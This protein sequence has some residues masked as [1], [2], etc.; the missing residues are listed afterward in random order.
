MK[1]FALSSHR[2]VVQPC[3]V[4]RMPILPWQVPCF[5]CH[6]WVPSLTNNITLATTKLTKM[7]RLNSND[8]IFTTVTLLHRLHGQNWTF[9]CL[10]YTPLLCLIT[11]ISCNTWTLSRTLVIIYTSWQKHEKKKGV[12][13]KKWKKERQRKTARGIYKIDRAISSTVKEN[14]RSN[15]SLVVPHD[16][17]VKGTRVFIVNVDLLS[18]WNCISYFL[19]YIM[20]KPCWLGTLRWLN[21]PIRSIMKI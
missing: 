18:R 15:L 20:Y 14:A 2:V 17:D 7:T 13:K 11:T 4:P 10:I 6:L 5:L 19:S 21:W 1:A 8:N 9:P 12:Q 3:M 16:L